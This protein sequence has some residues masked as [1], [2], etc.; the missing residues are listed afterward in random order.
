MTVAA[1]AIGWIIERVSRGWPEVDSGLMSPETG[2]ITEENGGM[3][4]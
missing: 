1:I 2:Q 3:T 4:K